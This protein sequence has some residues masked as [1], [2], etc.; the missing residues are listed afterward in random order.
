MMGTQE[1]QQETNGKSHAPGIGERVD[2]IGSS[3]Q[4]MWREA[5]S[6]VDDI[7]KSLDI[8]GRTERH[9]YGTML[10]ALGVG[11]LLGGGLFTSF[12]AR[13]FKLGFRLAAIPFVRQELMG[14]AG[15]ALDALQGKASEAK[16]GKQ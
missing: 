10:A 13:L 14:I 1:G 9:P 6:A 5:R 2:H 15:S 8:K 3:A 12:S 7:T 16:E 11:Y 4:Q